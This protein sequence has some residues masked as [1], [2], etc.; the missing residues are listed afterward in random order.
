M[1]PLEVSGRGVDASTCVNTP[2]PARVSC[3]MDPSSPASDA[4]EFWNRLYPPRSPRRL[5][6]ELRAKFPPRWRFLV[7][8]RRGASPWDAFVVVVP[9]RFAGRDG[10][11]GPVRVV[12]SAEAEHAHWALWMALRKRENGIRELA[13]LTKIWPAMPT[14]LPW[15]MPWFEMSTSEY[16][17][18]DQDEESSTTPDAP[19]AEA[20]SPARP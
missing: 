7:N 3:A 13:W 2:V 19:A 12:R 18:K 4:G 11:P 6:R 10:Q 8:L 15:Y 16:D 1:V 5:L 17:I 20:S 14:D 9:A